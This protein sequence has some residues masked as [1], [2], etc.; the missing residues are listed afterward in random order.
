MHT[1]IYNA[2]TNKKVQQSLLDA[3]FV[4][5]GDMAPLGMPYV[6]TKA[7]VITTICWF[8]DSSCAEGS[9]S[10]RFVSCHCSSQMLDGANDIASPPMI[11]L[12]P[13]MRGED[14]FFVFLM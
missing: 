10:G 8:V 4:D 11:D 12:L 9:R 3:N 2:A 6:L 13:Q 5:T 1:N 7:E 14:F